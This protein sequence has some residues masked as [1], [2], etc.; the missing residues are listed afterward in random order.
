MVF[1]RRS[2]HL[3]VYAATK[4]KRSVRRVQLPD[5]VVRLLRELQPLRVEPTT[6]LFTNLDGTPIEP[7]T[8]STHWYA[9][10]RAFGI[11]TRGLRLGERL[12][13]TA[14]SSLSSSVREI[15]RPMS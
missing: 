4:T 10:L 5:E 8:F 15:A 2:F 6:P 9:C 3:G 11:R 13:R 12:S 14:T 7:K 1:V